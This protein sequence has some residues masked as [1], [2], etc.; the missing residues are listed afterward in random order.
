METSVINTGNT[1]IDKFF[2]ASASAD[3]E[4][5]SREETSKVLDTLSDKHTTVKESSTAKDIEE[6]EMTLVEQYRARLKDLKID[7]DT[8]YSIID[9]MCDKG[10]YIEKVVIRPARGEKPELNVVFITRDSDTQGAIM[11]HALAGKHELQAIYDK[12]V[13]STQLAAS[14]LSF[15]GKTYSPIQDIEDKE[16]I[17]TELEQRAK[18][19]GKIPAPLMVTLL[20]KLAEFDLKVASAMAPGY[21]DFF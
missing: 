15:K 20:R 8:A 19:F 5:P 2:A 10:S 12:V 17:T 6:E 13:G 1:D 4:E 21:E 3:I 16:T 18:A 14:I 11:E 7:D 9:D